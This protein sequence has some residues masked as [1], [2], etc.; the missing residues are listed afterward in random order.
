MDKKELV[1]I[2][3]E[4][5]TWCKEKGNSRPKP[6]DLKSWTQ[7]NYPEVTV[8]EKFEDIVW[9]EFTGAGNKEEKISDKDL[10]KAFFVRKDKD[11]Y[12]ISIKSPTWAT[13]VRARDNQLLMTLARIGKADGAEEF[14]KLITSKKLNTFLNIQIKKAVKVQAEKENLFYVISGDNAKWAELTDGQLVE[15]PIFKKVCA[16]KSKKIDLSTVSNL[17]DFFAVVK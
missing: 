11:D 10:T 17:K 3:K 7:E 14:T 6:V 13:S 2:A 9:K 16:S 1:K 4:F 15:K 12:I 5:V 8:T